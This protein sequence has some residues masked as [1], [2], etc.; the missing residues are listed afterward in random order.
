MPL[1]KNAVY[2]LKTG[3]KAQ[4]Q[5]TNEYEM[6]SGQVS[7]SVLPRL[8][9]VLRDCY[10]PVI[11]VKPLLCRSCVHGVC[12]TQSR[13]WGKEETHETSAFLRSLADLSSTLCDASAS[14]TVNSEKEPVHSKSVIFR[15]V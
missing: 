14:L 5:K 6:Y 2:F 4:G 8:K 7:L 13:K 12:D 3:I 1:T 15:F 11:Q 9:D 10:N